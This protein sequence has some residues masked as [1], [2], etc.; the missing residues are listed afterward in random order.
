MNKFICL[1]LIFLAVA[2]EDYTLDE[3]VYVL[4]D[5]N[6]NK[7][8]SEFDFALVEFYAPWCGH[9]KK[10]APEY[11]IAA[12]KLAE[13]NPN[14][15]LCKV[16]ATIEK[17]HAGKFGVKGFPTLKFF[18]KGAAA[19]I[20]Y[21]G[22]RTAP[23]IIAWLK[24][25]TGPIS[26]ETSSVSTAEKSIADNELVGIF[27]GSPTSDAFS[28]F[29]VV[30]GS[31]EDVVFLNTNE[32]SVKEHYGAQDNTLILF[33]KFDDGKNVF[34]G[35]WNVEA[36][37][38]F[39][40]SNKFPTIMEFDQKAAQRIFGDGLSALFLLASDNSESKSA[41]EAFK[42]A[43]QDLKGKITLSI[44]KLGEGMGSR[45][46]EY[47]GVTETDC[48]TLRIVLPNEDMKKFKYEGEVTEQG[49][50]NFFDDWSN[51]R[52]KP[53]FKS[54]PL[55]E[56]NNEPVKIL[57]AKNFEEIVVNNDNDVLV[58]FYAPWCGHCKSLAPIYDTLA[59]KLE[60]TKGI[61]IAKM[62]A[63]ANEVEGV[64]VRG[65]PTIKFYKKGNKHSPMDFEGDRTEEGFIAFLKQHSSA[66]IDATATPTPS[67]DDHHGHDHGHDD[68][69]HDEP[70][71][72][73]DDSL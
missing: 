66:Q 5:A 12:Q 60:N 43:A 42:K 34:T 50:K 7:A 64:Q 55:P 20:D 68:H 44:A 53:F 8:I 47:I 27:F 3:G 11:A 49:I 24:K 18:I 4:G 73:K 71:R 69:G 14:I 39:I 16:D 36:A 58:E 56:S 33:K 63:T 23:E 72:H 19:P 38:D 29:T 35:P 67:H 17:E 9:C 40:T 41:V 37:K 21:E 57:V 1:A 28:T 26:V 2:A 32:D 10:L 6:F 54:E 15:K 52:L 25:R 61:T 31:N 48:P 13:S 62:D 51:G 70:A 30:A 65:F 45:L 46:A 59:K 22:G